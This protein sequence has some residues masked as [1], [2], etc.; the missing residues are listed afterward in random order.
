MEMLL[1]GKPCSAMMA[2]MTLAYGMYVII[3]FFIT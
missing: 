2:Q 1:G 3:A